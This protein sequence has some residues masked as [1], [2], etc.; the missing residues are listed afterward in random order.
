MK[1]SKKMNATSRIA[2]VTGMKK[3]SEMICGRVINDKGKTY[4][5]TIAPSGKTTCT[6]IDDITGK[7]EK[8]DGHARTGHCYHVEKTEEKKAEFPTFDE[9]AQLP[10]EDKPKVA[11][12][13]W[14][15]GTYRI[16]RQRSKKFYVQRYQAQ[17][18]GHNWSYDARFHSYK[19]EL[20][21]KKALDKLLGG[22]NV[23]TS[24]RR[25]DD[26]NFNR[27][28]LAIAR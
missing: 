11:T 12:A 20:G 7:R 1:G 3:P 6:Y 26:R 21:A 27:Q 17:P 13:V 10:T 18:N 15:D 14:S 2:I 24:K 8:C 28:A 16:L 25:D 5:T 22:K 23:K 9:L 19:T 4:F